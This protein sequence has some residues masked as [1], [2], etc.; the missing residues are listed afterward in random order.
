MDRLDLT[1]RYCYSREVLMTG[2]APWE[3]WTPGVLSKKQMKLLLER[4]NL[5]ATEAFLG[6]SSLD[7]TLS[8]EAYRLPQGTIKPSG[9]LYHKS[10]ELLGEPLPAIDASQGMVLNPRENYLVKLQE[11]LH[12]LEDSFIYGQATAKSSVGRIDVLARLVVDGMDCY[13]FFNPA[14]SGGDLFLEITPLTFPIRIRPGISLS[15]LR[16]FFGSPEGCRLHGK[17][18]NQTFLRDSIKGDDT[19]SVDL[20]PVTISGHQV[21]AFR[22][23]Q[24]EN[25]RPLVLWEKT[26]DPWDYWEF[27]L[28]DSSRRLSLRKGLFY[29]LKSKE[30]LA[31]PKGAAVYCR[32][33]DESLGEMRI[34]YAGFAHPLFG[35]SRADLKVGTPLIFEVR[36]HDVNVS[37][38][39][40]ESMARLQFYRM[41]EDAADEDADRAG[42][43]E[44]QTLKLSHFFRPWPE[45]VVVSDDGTVTPC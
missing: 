1:L 43:Y 30:L 8:S 21:I 42:P 5:R 3:E 38:Q 13:E 39:D 23:K 35:R 32:A 6:A 19:L 7:L 44:D 28:P 24:S 34:H 16:L 15:Q 10:I 45:K 25:L 26:A 18:A 37:L 41:S 36:G 12:G 29:I 14:K 17:E 22:A 11:R 4:G 20:D 27:V 2:P 33:I 9:P 40:G 31:L